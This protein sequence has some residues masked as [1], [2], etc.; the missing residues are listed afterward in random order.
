MIII[1]EWIR[2]IFMIVVSISFIEIILPGGR[3]T[4]Y[5]KFVF[6]TIMIAV[7]IHP[8]ADLAGRGNEDI[9]A[10]QQG[11]F[12]AVADEPEFTEKYTFYTID[13]AGIYKSKVLEKTS[14]VLRENFQ[15][16][17]IISVDVSLD[18]RSVSQGGGGIHSIQVTVGSDADTKQIRQKIS[19]EMGIDKS[20]VIVK[21][22]K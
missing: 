19:E 5:L 11:S 10:F 15:D 2:N 14:D 22:E 18:E 1:N 3:M 4:K 9:T 17:E 7:I 16:V 13:I 21:K 12:T 20:R 6:S 8:L